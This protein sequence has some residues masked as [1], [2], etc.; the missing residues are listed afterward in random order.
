MVYVDNGSLVC[1]TQV[2]GVFSATTAENGTVSLAV[3]TSAYQVTGTFGGFS[4]DSPFPSGDVY[5]HVSGAG[6]NAAGTP[7]GYSYSGRFY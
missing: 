7:T 3:I 2:D 5:F 4:N 1:Q 6:V